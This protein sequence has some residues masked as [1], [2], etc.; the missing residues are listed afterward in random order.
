[1]SGHGNASRLPVGSRFARVTAV[2]AALVFALAACGGG[3]DTSTVDSGDGAAA[4]RATETTLTVS[5]AASLAE[6]FEAIG[7]AFSEQN[8]GVSVRFNFGA[9]GT[10]STQ[11]AEGAPADVAAFASSASMDRLVADSLVAAPITF[12]TNRLVIVTQP[13]NP[14]G[15][16]GLD[17]LA[18]GGIVALCGEAAPCGTYARNVLNAA[19]V[20]ISPTRITIGDDVKATLGAVSNGDADAALVY[21]SDAIAAGDAVTSVE[22]PESSAEL[23]VYPIAVLTGTPHTQVAQRFVN[24]VLSDAGREILAAAGFGFDVEPEAGVEAEAGSGSG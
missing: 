7:Q 6:S 4:N 12:A 23:A 14:T 16:D 21:R 17:D 19:G 9:S 18:D 5:A 8:E 1:M 22:F 3:S 13:G 11:I 2:F 10:L 15:I 20:A 24:F